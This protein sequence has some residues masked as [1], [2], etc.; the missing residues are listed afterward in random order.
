MKKKITHSRN[1]LTGILLAFFALGIL[2]VA[3]FFLF[4]KYSQPPSLAKILP[5]AETL[6]FAEIQT[7]VENPEW[8][9]LRKIFAESSPAELGN[10]DSLGF[11]DAAEFLGLLRNRIGIAFFGE[12]LN[13]D[14]FLLALD[15]E[16]VE[17]A[18][19]FLAA[20]T[21]A[22]ES[23][24]EE[25]YLHQKIYFY[26]RSRKL[27]FFFFGND[28]LL[29]SER[30]DLEKIAETIHDSAKSLKNSIAFQAIAQKINPRATGF[31]YFSEK[32]IQQTFTANLGGMRNALA[33]PLL[34]FFGSA[35]ATLAPRDEGVQLAVQL[36]LKDKFVRANLFAEA[37]TVNFELLNF[38]GEETKIFGAAKNPSAQLSH[39]LTAS[40]KTNP[41]FP[42]LLKGV[43]T[44]FTREWFGETADFSEDFAS[45]FE[46]A[47][48]LGKTNSGGFF[49]IFEN[50]ESEILLE[51]LISSRGKLAAE[52]KLVALPDTT[53]GYELAAKSE[54]TVTEEL[55]AS[56]KI[57]RLHFPKYELNFA[58]LENRLVF[59]SEKEVLEKMVARFV[60]EEKVFGNLL[61]ESGIAEGNIFYLRVENSEN[62]FL[63]PFRFA[64]AGVNF[65]VDG[66]KMEIFLGK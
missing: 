14:R 46:N 28:L 25:N 48:V 21:L 43:A 47:S 19:E 22:G 50:A 35:G 2:G 39:F 6:F 59:A 55:F 58:E 20:Q 9:N 64:L 36:A 40:K 63:K 23:L 5:E 33:T 29:A 60:A 54:P 3:G 38:L 16:N 37:E 42:L 15:V 7:S 32:L 26:P 45:L 66:V 56:H 17:T 31:A 61:A 57:T 18:R 65:G 53:P 34:D 41:A 8:I 62:L 10:F 44:K 13:P 27:A 11:T 30:K 49:G 1:I 52:E 12:S 51:K 24:A 4:S